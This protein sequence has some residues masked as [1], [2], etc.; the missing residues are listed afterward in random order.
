MTQENQTLKEEQQL[1]NHVLQKQILD[2]FQRETE[3]M[4]KK[5]AAQLDLSAKE[6]KDL[7]HQ[8]WSREQAMIKEYTM[9]MDLKKK[10]I[11]EMS[12]QSTKQLQELK[13]ENQKLKKEIEKLIKKRHTR[14]T[15]ASRS[16]NQ[17]DI[18]KSTATKV[19]E[20]K[21]EPEICKKIRYSD[22]D[23]STRNEDPST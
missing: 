8:A 2:K 20:F 22:R 9:Q 11:E 19:Y 14:S 10:R 1:E 21:V 5:L 4:N 16:K 18:G 17:M 12:R 7:Q 3:D 6:K 13:T 15:S 23:E